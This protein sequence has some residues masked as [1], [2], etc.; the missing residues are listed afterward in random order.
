MHVKVKVAEG[1][2]MPCFV[3]IPKLDKKQFR[4]LQKGKEVAVPEET[5]AHLL[6]RGV[7]TE[8]K[9][10]VIPKGGDD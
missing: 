6:S 8:C 3:T 2:K 5:A 4:E 1:Q 10:K 7:V 9:T